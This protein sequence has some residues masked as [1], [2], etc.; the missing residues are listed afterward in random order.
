M[1]F[2]KCPD[3]MD[4]KW[5]QNVTEHALPLY[6]TL[7]MS[8][9]HHISIK[10]LLVVHVKDTNYDNTKPGCFQSRSCGQRHCAACAAHRIGSGLPP[11]HS[12]RRLDSIASRYSELPRP[13]LED[14][15][16]E[17]IPPTNPKPN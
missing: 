9:F 15:R 11:A 14:K 12:S 10:L 5:D 8:S 1:D 7:R 16:Q 4:W 13:D 2:L 3:P 17:M 6:D